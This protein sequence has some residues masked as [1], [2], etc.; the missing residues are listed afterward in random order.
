VQ[1]TG[2]AVECAI[3]REQLRRNCELFDASDASARGLVAAGA[4]DQPGDHPGAHKGVVDIGT[5]DQTNILAGACPA[6][7]LVPVSHFG[8]VTLPFS[9]LC[10]PAEILGNVLVAI[11]AL[12]C[13]G[14]V[15]VRGS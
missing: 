4:G 7:V 15:F 5:F 6:D 8:S 1:C 3:V 12:A 13:V 2:D 10:G 14:I 9:K 11:T